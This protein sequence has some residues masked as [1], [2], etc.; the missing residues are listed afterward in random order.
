MFYNGAFL[1]GMMETLI[2]GLHIRTVV[3]N[4]SVSK[5]SFYI[6]HKS[7]KKIHRSINV[8]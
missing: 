3:F 6:T 5:L 8:T 1:F 2:Q 4:N 7:K